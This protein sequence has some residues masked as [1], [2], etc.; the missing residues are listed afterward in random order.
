[1]FSAGIGIGLVSWSFVEPIHYFSTPPLGIE[2]KSSSAAEWG[3]M[4]AQFHWSFVS[5]ALYAVASVPVA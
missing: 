5:W 4:Y 2:A 1:M 3:H